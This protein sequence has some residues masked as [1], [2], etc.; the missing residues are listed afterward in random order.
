MGSYI[1]NG[2]GYAIAWWNDVD[3]FSENFTAE[4]GSC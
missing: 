3:V 1:C 4:G 2:S